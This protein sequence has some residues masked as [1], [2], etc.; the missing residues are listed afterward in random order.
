VTRRIPQKRIDRFQAVKY[1][2]VGASLLDSA[3]VLEAVAAEDDRFGNAIGIIAIHA[4]IAY[5]DTLSIAYREVKSAAGDHRAAADVLRDAL[6]PSADPAMIN[7]F[8][9]LLARKDQVSYTGTFFGMDDAMRLLAE[10]RTFCEWAEDLYARRPAVPGTKSQKSAEQDGTWRHTTVTLKPQNPEYA[11]IVITVEDEG[12]LQ[13][14]A[15]F[16]RVVNG[17]VTGD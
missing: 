9:A 10:S 12:E 11:P 5:A 8:G 13:V 1:H 14:V 17:E 16:V 4:A 3:E 2:R 15:E 6:G 7:R